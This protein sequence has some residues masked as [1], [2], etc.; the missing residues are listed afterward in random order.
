[1]TMYLGQKEM[2]HQTLNRILKHT[3]SEYPKVSV[4][5]ETIKLGQDGLKSTFRAHIIQ[6]KSVGIYLE[7]E[8]DSESRA[9]EYSAEYVRNV[10]ENGNI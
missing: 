3:E 8:F 7:I 4:P 9:L 6:S 5:L 1:M 2:T 10:R